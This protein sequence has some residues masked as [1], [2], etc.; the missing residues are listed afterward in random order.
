MM[1]DDVPAPIGRVVATE[2]K[3]NTPHEFHFWTAVESSVG[4]GTIVR[5]DGTTPINGV[6]PHIYGVVT[7]G[8]SYSDLQSPLHDVMGHD[9]APG[10]AG[11]GRRVTG[12]CRSSQSCHGGRSLV[13][14]PA[15]RRRVRNGRASQ[16]GNVGQS[17]WMDETGVGGLL[18]FKTLA[19]GR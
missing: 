17:A 18:T 2:R 3:P 19:G 16:W 4:I 11:W 15:T 8:F 9:G 10:H 7:E 1:Q 6:I 14:R 5:V 12:Y 13:T